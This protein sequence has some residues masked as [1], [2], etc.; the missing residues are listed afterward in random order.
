VTAYP[1][2]G[3]QGVAFRVRLFQLLPESAHR[4][5]GE[6]VLKQPEGSDDGHGGR[7]MRPIVEVGEEKRLRELR[8]TKHAADEVLAHA[9]GDTEAERLRTEERHDQRLEPHPAI[10]SLKISDRLAERVEVRGCAVA[11]LRESAW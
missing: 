3:N 2:F 5:L 4:Q 1:Q 8:E 10:T 7:L 6:Q 11:K 9:V